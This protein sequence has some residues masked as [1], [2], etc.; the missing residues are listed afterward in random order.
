MCSK[1]LKA[2]YVTSGGGRV[3]SRIGQRVE[4]RGILELTHAS[5][6]DQ[7]FDW[8]TSQFKDCR[9]VVCLSGGLDSSVIA[10]F[11]ATRLS[12]VAPA[13]FT[14]LNHDDLQR[15]GLRA[16]VAELAVSEDFHCAAAVAGALELPLLPVVRA[17]VAVAGVVQTSVHLWQYWRDFNVHCATVNLFLAEDIC[18]AFAGERGVVL[19]GDLMNEYVC[20]Y[21]EERVGSTAYDKIPRIPMGKRRRY[22]VRS[23]RR[24]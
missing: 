13:T 18:A 11:A 10:S 7:A 17:R 4:R 6:L 24:R 21:R 2:A 20:D 15:R 19:T 8:I 12:N 14:Y 9:F 1:Y 23:R 5:F 3:R 16:P 22:F